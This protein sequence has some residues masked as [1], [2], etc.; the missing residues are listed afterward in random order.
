MA[1]LLCVEKRKSVGITFIFN[2]VV[3]LLSNLQLQNIRQKIFLMVIIPAVK[4]LYLRLYLYL[5]CK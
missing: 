2:L 5:R 1:K 4:Y 3:S